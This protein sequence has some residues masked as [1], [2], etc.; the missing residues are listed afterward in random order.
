MVRPILEY[1]AII[2]SPHSYS[3]EYWFSVEAVQRR[4]ARFIFNNRSQY[5]SV[6]DMLRFKSLADSRGEMN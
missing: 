3:E 4:S 1:A 6:T 5:A 2:W